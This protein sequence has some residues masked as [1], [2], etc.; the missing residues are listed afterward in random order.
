M[1]IVLKPH[2]KFMETKISTNP[3]NSEAPPDSLRLLGVLILGFIVRV[4]Y[5]SSLNQ[6]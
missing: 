1:A 6:V 5:T 4:T 3:V 2:K